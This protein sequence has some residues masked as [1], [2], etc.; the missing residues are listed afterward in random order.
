[1]LRV[2]QGSRLRQHLPQERLALHEREGPQV[3]P[4][5]R[6]QVEEIERAGRL[7]GGMPD[8]RGASDARAVLQALKAR[9]P[10]L[11]Q[12]HQLPV[13]EQARVRQCG[14]RANQL[15]EGRGVIVPV[16]RDQ[17]RR[18]VF[19]HYPHAIAV[20]LYL[21]D[22]PGAREWLLARFREHGSDILGTDGAHG[23]L[24]LLQLGHELGRFLV[25]VA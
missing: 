17:P 1:M 14:D 2:P 7:D 3:E 23:R 22:P 24:E 9:P 20:E 18:P 12:D 4:L 19:L 21:K 8:L 13:H 5:D 25:A 6:H 15:G 16:A 10:L 11:V